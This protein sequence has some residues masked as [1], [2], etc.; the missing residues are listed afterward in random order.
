MVISVTS[1]FKVAAVADDDKSHKT[2]NKLG[3]RLERRRTFLILILSVRYPLLFLPG[4]L[5]YRAFLVICVRYNNQAQCRT[6]RVIGQIH[7]RDWCETSVAF[8]A[9]IYENS[10]V[11]HLLEKKTLLQSCATFCCTAL[12]TAKRKITV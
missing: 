5:I 1:V 3:T 10:R 8:R 4:K 6:D 9:W 12:T 2:G 7:V 11:N